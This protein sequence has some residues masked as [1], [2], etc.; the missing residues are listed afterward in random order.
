MLKFY[1]NLEVNEIAKKKELFEFQIN[2]STFLMIPY[3]RTEKELEEIYQ[4]CVEL[5]KRNIP[6]HTFILNKENKIITNIYIYTLS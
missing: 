5:K 2:Q 6:V 4:V 3:L 1:Y